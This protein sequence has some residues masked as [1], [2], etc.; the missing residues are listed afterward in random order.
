MGI[1]L[2]WVIMR[3]VAVINRRFGATYRFHFQGS[4]VQNSLGFLAPE[5]GTDR[6]LETSVKKLPLLA[7]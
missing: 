1:A 3:R 6:L 5:D 7:A 2:F 4:R